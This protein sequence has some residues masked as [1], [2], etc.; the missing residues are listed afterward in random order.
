M[1]ELLFLRY[2]GRHLLRDERSKTS[3]K[4]LKLVSNASKDVSCAYKIRRA[5]A[6][7]PLSAYLCDVKTE[8]ATLELKP[9]LEVSNVT[10]WD[11]E[12]ACEER[13][14]R[15]CFILGVTLNHFPL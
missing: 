4:S 12:C 2:K 13:Y 5:F 8:N 14:A 9:L 11:A 3:E 7:L 6:H 10:L 1:G 15:A